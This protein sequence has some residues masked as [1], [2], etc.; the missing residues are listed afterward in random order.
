[1]ILVRFLLASAILSVAIL[2]NSAVNAA[3]SAS[4]DSPALTARLITAENGIRPGAR[5]V[6]AALSLALGEGWK[7]YWRSPGEVGF[8]PEIDWTGSKNLAA[9]E[10]QYPAP[11]RFRAFGI[12]NFGYEHAVTYPIQ[13]TVGDPGAALTL[14]ARVSV[15]VCS[16]V[17]IPLH[18]DL[19][20]SLPPGTGIDQTSAAEI[21]LWAARVPVDG[22]SSD[23][24]LRSADLT[25]DQG[26]LVVELERPAGWQD[27]DIFPELGDGTAFGAS[28]IRLSPDNSLLWARLPVLSLAD[29]PSPL[30]LTV[31]DSDSAVTFGE[32]PLGAVPAE[33]PFTIAPPGR[34]AAVLIWIAL[35]AF[36]GGLILN[37]M[38][39]VLP[40]LSIKL[41]SALKVATGSH[42][43]I[44]FG[45]LATAFGTLSFM[46]A[47]AALVL[48]LQSLG[49]AVGWGT[50]FQN[51]FFLVFL[52]LVLGLFA[53]SLFGLFEIPLP[54]GLAT[55]LAGPG[56]D[57]Y[58]R[59]FATGAFAAILA[60]PCSA[61]LLGTAIA[62]ALTGSV[63]DVFV[64]FS[65][66]GIGLA[67]PY[68]IVAAQPRLIAA[69]PRPGR[70]MLVVKAVLGA[71]LLATA[72]WLFWVLSGVSSPV[73][74]GW[75]AAALIAAIL[76]FAASRWGFPMARWAPLFAVPAV[77]AAL[78]L[79]AFIN[80]EERVAPRDEAVD[81][82]GFER[83]EI[84][85]HVSQGHVVFVD[86]TADWCLTCKANKA[87]V[88]DREPVVDALASPAVVAMQADWTRPD[89]QI[90]TYLEANG[91]FGIPFNIVYGPAAPEGLP[92]SEI[93][94]PGAVMEALE[95][96][97]GAPIELARSSPD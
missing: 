27:P 35:L 18:F 33:P 78:A 17:C 12:E 86:V 58:V 13:L 44:R 25:D 69:L 15:L 75:V 42:R 50:Q 85:R 31:T 29:P 72:A 39:C 53:A 77:G 65:A 2:A 21:A 66:M 84:A 49:Y 82:V 60:T 70:W 40:V 80:V 28:D 68:L 47:L 71:L 19:T 87:L 14:K 94:T 83:A 63:L 88:L 57:G 16:D 24:V 20:L 8:P 59:D 93:L 89:P 1:M 10:F 3:Q 95:A 46:W 9:A 96:A 74:A 48:G 64:V 45:F 91:R 22:N 55:R 36:G 32:V 56:R 23:I 90:Q 92:L 81:W 4:F 62:F 37:A 7:T 76:G 41:S 61:P 38:P 73:L 67:L 79:P 97:L 6:S 5:T 51:P 54:T 11:T 34:E 52:I 26:A 43:R 30:A